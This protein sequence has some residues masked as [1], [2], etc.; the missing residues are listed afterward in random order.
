MRALAW[1]GYRNARD[2]GGLPT[3]ASETGATIFGRVA[4]GPRRELLTETGWQDARRW[5][6]ATIVDLRCA[7][8]IGA[9]EGDPAVRPETFTTVPVVNAPTEDQDDPEFRETCFPILDS[10]EYW[11]HNWRILPDL[12]LGALTAIAAAPAGVLVHCSAGRDRTGMISTLLLSNADVAPADVAADY[13]ESV[14]A[15]AGTQTHSPT[16]DRQAAWGPD[17]VASWIAQ[18]SP[19]V[20]DIAADPDAAFGAIGAGSDL[21]GRLRALLTE[22]RSGPALQ[23]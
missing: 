9:R 1:D 12:V 23:R 21:R 5:G 3:P 13:A 19:I 10:P 18:T 17:E 8:E 7:H 6:L 22:Q 15:M 11:R 16:G 14:R 20:E 4:R 2:L